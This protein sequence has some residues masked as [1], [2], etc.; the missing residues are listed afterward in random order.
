MASSFL[1]YAPSITTSAVTVSSSLKF[2]VDYPLRSSFS[3]R[4]YVHARTSETASSLTV[5]FRLSNGLPIKA[6]HLIIGGVSSLLA[7]GVDSIKLQGSNDGV[8]WVDQIGTTNSLASKI[9]DGPYNDDII[10]TATK[11]DDLSGVLASYLRFR[12]VMAKVASPSAVAYAFRK[13]YMGEA[14]DMGEEPATYDLELVADDDQDTWQYPRGHFIMSKAFRPKHRI[15]VEWDGVTDAK[16]NE[17]AEKFLGDP[18]RNTVYLYTQTHKDPLY[19]NVL[20]HCRVV[21]DNTQIVKANDVENWNN[22]TA[23]FE[24]A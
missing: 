4:S 7:A 23:V 18:Y 11:N 12:V 17:F 13:L 2:D 20:M 19:D 16:A 8:T 14:F 3:G 24:E 10:F 5:T 15:T 9:K 1:I 22:I 6:D 21:P